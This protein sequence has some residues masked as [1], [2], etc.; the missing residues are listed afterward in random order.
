VSEQPVKL[1]E[2]NKKTVA[3]FKWL[4]AI[5]ESSYQN[6]AL[7]LKAKSELEKNGKLIEEA[8]N[9]AVRPEFADYIPLI[10][11]LLSGKSA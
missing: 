3:V 4:S 8:I 1:P 2:P 11:Q 5:L 7:L 6:P 10:K 9:D